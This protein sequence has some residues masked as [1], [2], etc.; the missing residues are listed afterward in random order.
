[1]KRYYGQK[2]AVKNFRRGTGTGF[3]S[4][5][6][7]VPVPVR[8][9]VPVK[10][11]TEENLGR[12]TRSKARKNQ[13]EKFVEIA[14]VGF[15]R[16]KKKLTTVEFNPSLNLFKRDFNSSFSFSTCWTYDPPEE[17][18]IWAAEFE[19]ARLKTFNG[20]DSGVR[21]S[22]GEEGASG[23]QPSS[24]GSTSGTRAYLVREKI[25]REKEER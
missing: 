23:S 1:V 18:S 19:E 20:K 3:G 17:A 2:I 7:P 4:V 16:G 14:R 8:V 25:G 22:E 11:G 21:G 15:F 9:S 6:V 5:P 10:R 12:G 24:A 13:D